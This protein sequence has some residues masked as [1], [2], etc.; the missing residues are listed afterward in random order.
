VAPLAKWASVSDRKV[1][2]EPSVAI[3]PADNCVIHN[4][5]TTHSF[6]NCEHGKV[7]APVA[8]P[9]P[10]LRSGQGADV[11]RQDDRAPNALPNKTRER[12]VLPAQV[13][14]FPHGRVIGEHVG[15]E[16]DANRPD[17]V[18]PIERANR[19]RNLLHHFVDVTRGQLT[20]V[21]LHNAAS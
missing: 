3:V 19:L 17:L 2:D 15:G 4:E 18:G 8:G 9:E 16:A 5:P 20:L 10:V 13:G 1:T 12:D 11:V 14:S 7:R 6:A 21:L